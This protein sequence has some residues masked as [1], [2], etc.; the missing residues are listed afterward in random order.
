M[1]ATVTYLIGDATEPLGIGYKMICHVCNNMGRWGAGFTAALDKKWPV[2]GRKFRH[3]SPAI[4]LTQ[5]IAVEKDIWVVNLVAQRGLRGAS[6]PHPLDC[7]V[8]SDCLEDMAA[9]I[10]SAPYNTDYFQM[11]GDPSLPQNSFSVHMPRI[12]CGLAGGNWKREVLPLINQM[13]IASDIPVFVYDL[14]PFATP[15]GNL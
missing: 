4:G 6:N 10:K 8:L 13:L 5:F 7:S 11:Q 9:A 3:D 2:I 14:P 12:G 15:P 1:Q